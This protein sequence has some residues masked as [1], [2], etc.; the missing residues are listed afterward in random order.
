MARPDFGIEATAADAQV[1]YH[2]PFAKTSSQKYT[3]L[4]KFYLFFGKSTV[5]SEFD[6]VLKNCDLRIFPMQLVLKKSDS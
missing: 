6:E 3:T 5:R 4:V 2:A 1:K